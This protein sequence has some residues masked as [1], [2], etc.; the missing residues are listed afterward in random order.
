MC[1]TKIERVFEQ[2]VRRY[3]EQQ[4]WQEDEYIVYPAEKGRLLTAACD[5]DIVRWNYLVRLP[6]VCHKCWRSCYQHFDELVAPQKVIVLIVFS[7]VKLTTRVLG[8]APVSNF[9]YSG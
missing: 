8:R 5:V 2:Y 9:Q 7:L 1:V 4:K 6:M 3:D